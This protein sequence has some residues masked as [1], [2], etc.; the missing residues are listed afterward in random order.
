MLK[1]LTD[2]FT[3]PA[4]T[5]A[6]TASDVV[7]NSTT[8]G[9]V[10]P[11]SWNIGGKGGKLWS[12]RLEKS[13]GTDVVNSSM[14]LHLYGEAVVTAAGDNAA[15][16]TP[17]NEHIVNLTVPIFVAYTDDASVEYKVGESGFLSPILLPYHTVYGLLSATAGYTPASAEVFVVDLHV[18]IN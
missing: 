14:I 7:A 17:V 5:N 4:D 11:L 12:V 3:R 9:S 16:S 18:E 13:D 2:T 1:K 8:A 15:F 6:Y 10:I